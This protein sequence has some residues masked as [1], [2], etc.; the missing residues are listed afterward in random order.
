MYMVT[1]MNIQISNFQCSI[2]SECSITNFQCSINS[3]KSMS[4]QPVEKHGSVRC[5]VIETLDIH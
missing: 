1:R 2:Y 4:K 3:S 5:L